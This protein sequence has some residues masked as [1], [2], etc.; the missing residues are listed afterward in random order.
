MARNLTSNATVTI[1]MN[2]RQ[3]N[4]TMKNLEK[5]AERLQ[6]QFEKAKAA[7]DKVAMD[8][9]HKSL[10]EINSQLKVLKTNTTAVEEVMRKLDRATPAELNKTLSTLRRQLNGMA[11]GSDVWDK[12]VAKIKLVE[13]EIRKVNAALRTQESGWNRMNTWLNNAQTALMGF[14]A[15]LTGLIMAGRKAVNAYAGM[16]DQLAN[17]R[18]YT[19]MT[20]DKVDELQDAF[21]RIDTRST[22]DQLNLLA[23]EG[24]RLGKNTMESVQGYVEAADIINVALVDLGEGATQTIAKIANIFGVEQQLGTKDAMLS[25]GSAVNVL[26]QNCTASKP[27]LVEFAQRMAGIGSQAGLTVPQILA[28]GAVL[29]ANGQK[30]EMSATAIQKIIMALANK[31][32]EFSKVLGL[33]AEKLAKTLRSSAK[34]GILMY[35]DAIKQ[36]S[37]KTSA[38]NA[39]IA[40]APLFKDM[41]MDAA[42]VAT[43]LSTL[44]NHIDELRWQFGEADKAFREATSATKEYEI[45]NNTAQASIDKARKRVNELAIELGEKLFPIMKHIYTSSGIFLRVLNT[46]V[47]FIIRHR[48]EIVVLTSAIVGYGVA[49]ALAAVKTKVFTAAQVSATA[50]VSAGKAAILL[51]QSAFYMLIGRIDLA[52]VRWRAL[53]MVIKSSPWGLAVAAVTALGTALYTAANRAGTF[54]DYVNKLKDST[55]KWN[56]ETVK[57]QR[58][59]DILIGKMEGA[60]E[61]TQEYEEARNAIISQYGRYLEGLVTEEGKIIDLQ[62]AYDR[63]TKAIQRNSLA[64]GINAVQDKLNEDYAQNLADNLK[65]LQEQLEYFGM[66]TKEAT[67]LVTRVARNIS[68]GENISEEDT[69]RINEFSA[70]RVGGDSWWEGFKS[71]FNNSLPTSWGEKLSNALGLDLIHTDKSPAEIMNQ[72]YYD[73]HALGS[74]MDKVE[75]MKDG[76]DPDRHIDNSVLRLAIDSIRKAITQAE[77]EG[78]EEYSGNV[79]VLTVSGNNVGEMTSMTLASARKLLKEYEE[80]WGLRGLGSSVVK[81]K[82]EQNLDFEDEPYVSEKDK[83]AAD[84]KAAAEARRELLKAKQEFRDGLNAIKAEYQKKDSEVVRS[85]AKGETDYLSYLKARNDAEQDYYDRSRNFYEEQFSTIKDS[86]IE[87]DKDYQALLKKKTEAL[88]KYEDTRISY[89]SQ[90]IRKRATFDEQVVTEDAK[91]QE[92]RSLDDE[93]R[94][95]NQILKIRTDALKMQ[96]DL[97]AKGTKEWENL[98]LQL[99]QTEEAARL[100]NERLYLQKLNDVRKEYNELG[101]VERYRIEL[102]ILRQ[103]FLAETMQLEEYE[104][105]KQQLRKKYSKDLPGNDFKKSPE[106]TKAQRKKEREKQ[107]SQIDAAVEGGIISEDEGK[108]RKDALDSSYI[109]ELIEKVKGCGNEW[110]SMIATVSNAWRHLWKTVGEGGNILDN[111]GEVAGATFAV[112][113][114]GMQIASQFAQSNAQI[115]QKKIEKRYEREAELAQGNS[116]LLAKLEK[117]KE[118]EIAEVKNKA[119]RQAFA[120]QVIQ[121]LAQA[122]QG[123]INAYTSTAAIPVVGPALA[124][125][126][127]AVAVAAGMVNVALLKKQQEA[128]ESTGYA[129]GGYTRPGRKYE[130]AGVVHA[131]EWVA[132]QELLSSPVARPIIQML[133]KAQRENRIGSLGAAESSRVVMSANYGSSLSGT[134]REG[135]SVIVREAATDNRTLSELAA[136]VDRLARRLDEPIVAEASITGRRGIRTK[137]DEYDRLIRNKKIVR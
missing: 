104:K 136:V 71:Y 57:E 10:K 120:M 99:E 134:P 82:V 115:E 97:Y 9:A 59:L 43:V 86:Y 22:R 45:F 54:E 29:D 85:Y 112:V 14:A 34:D 65:A 66:E 1:S 52:A 107:F 80:K 17:T 102:A 18:K 83:E 106:E 87:D 119:S 103:L 23:Q 128:A 16:D 130:V 32:E 40:I 39:T 94:L 58:E 89:E 96:M 76:M 93:I 79:T 56:K 37:E 26:S 69:Q 19:G 15:A 72:I 25:I 75:A 46:I 36:L 110:V 31:N 109:D 88:K 100:S 3:A 20:S 77:K 70:K 68:A 49:V 67:A 5:E 92:S 60:R 95:Q 116:Y 108:R 61:G 127:A 44:A 113:T 114:A 135:D 123:G 101:A 2:G 78:K 12:Q 84:K 27:Y 132:S 121:A 7:G 35:L 48:T 122:I 21:N 118:E 33:D 8:K 126:A 90:R 125:A 105:L 63:L 131:G 30:V 117:Q 42:R 81:E 50:A 73:R 124:P 6:K 137:L 51:M 13:A 64:K 129:E 62:A 98:K 11:R 41:G 4:E 91:L 38:S 28:F 133:D 53:S 74:G 47:S 111:I 24:G 55:F